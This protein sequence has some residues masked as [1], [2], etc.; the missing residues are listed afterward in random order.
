LI[1]FCRNVLGREYLDQSEDVLS[2]LGGSVERRDQVFTVR[3]APC[4]GGV[5]SRTSLPVSSPCRTSSRRST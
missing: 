1:P 4:Q 3:R 2:V 5:R